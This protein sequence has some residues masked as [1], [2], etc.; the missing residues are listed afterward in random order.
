MP[1]DMNS[2]HHDASLLAPEALQGARA[3][4][5]QVVWLRGDED[6][7]TEFCLEADAVMAMLDIKRSRL[8][9]IS[10]RELRV[11]RI[12]RGRY[13]SPVYRPCDVQEYRAWARA[14]AT[15]LKQQETIAEAVGQL[16]DI[17]RELKVKADLAIEASHE[18]LENKVRAVLGQEFR[19]GMM[20]LLQELMAQQQRQAL[21]EQEV[22]RN[23]QHL[24]HGLNMLNRQLQHQNQLLKAMAQQGDVTAHQLITM[25]AEQR[26]GLQENKSAAMDLQAERLKQRRQAAEQNRWSRRERSPLQGPRGALRAQRLRAERG[27]P[28]AQIP[29]PIAPNSADEQRAPAG[30]QEVRPPK[31]DAAVASRLRQLQ[32]YRRR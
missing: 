3:E 4:L 25:A 12:R 20:P 24:E 16:E 11:G 14:T 27:E 10:G 8:T 29:V 15:R 5:P 28:A 1:E 6:Y 18:Q 21:H 19:Q 7:C 26:L 30:Q 13:V 17:G 2:I 32:R 31:R 9:Q 22:R 23:I